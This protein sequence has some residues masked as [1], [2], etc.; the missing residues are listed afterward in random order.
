MFNAFTI[1]AGEF[2]VVPLCYV[3]M[4]RRLTQ[5]YIALFKKLQELFGDFAVREIISDF[6]PAVWRAVRESF[7]NLQQHIGCLFHWAQAVVKTI[8]NLRLFRL[9]GD[10]KLTVYNL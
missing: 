3:M 10:K 2:K 6:E 4:T 7:P 8:K 1:L 5:D 9:T